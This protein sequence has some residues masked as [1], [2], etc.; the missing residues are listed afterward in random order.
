M[1]PKTTARRRK[2]RELTEPN[3]PPELGW[4]RDF[5]RELQ[6]LTAE[7]DGEVEETPEGA[8]LYRF[9]EIL[10]SFQ[11]A[12]VVRQHLS[13]D[14]QSVGDIVYSSDESEEEADRREVEEF[15]RELGRQK[16]LEAYVQDPN[17]LGYMDD[18]ELVA[19]DEELKRRRAIS[20]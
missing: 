15:E 16:E 1:L 10:R 2:G 12:E 4:D 14:D 17:R 9:P 19:F 3:L 5:L 20:A 6:A 8:A 11:S 7:F 18:F 13:L